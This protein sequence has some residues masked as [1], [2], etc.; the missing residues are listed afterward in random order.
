MS[1]E[2][3]PLQR[4]DPFRWRIPATSRKQ[5]RV[6]GLIYADDE[7]IERIIRDNA[8]HQVASVATLPGILEHALGMP[9][10]HR[11]YG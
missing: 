4:L 5:L 8:L 1:K 2:H 9:D 6:P 10:I 3:I 7:P 11:G